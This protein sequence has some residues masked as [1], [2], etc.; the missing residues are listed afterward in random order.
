LRFFPN[1]FKL[2]LLTT[3]AV[4]DTSAAF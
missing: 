1:E 4:S 2:D 3:S